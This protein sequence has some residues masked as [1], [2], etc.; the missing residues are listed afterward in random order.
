MNPTEV[1]E[2]I[3]IDSGFVNDDSVYMFPDAGIND[4]VSPQPFAVDVNEQPV[5]CNPEL[6][7]HDVSWRTL[8]S[9]DRMPSNDLH[10]GHRRNQA[11]RRTAC[12]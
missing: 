3:S 7:G 1:G 8:I 11:W 4:S 6:I 5:E 2:Q 9:S 12:T 10:I